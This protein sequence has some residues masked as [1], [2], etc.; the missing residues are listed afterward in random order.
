MASKKPVGTF[1]HDQLRIIGVHVYSWDGGEAF[2][3][4]TNVVSSPPPPRLAD[5]SIY[6]LSIPYTSISFVL[7]FI[8]PVISHL[9]K[10]FFDRI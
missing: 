4:P 9:N 7:T 5:S 3:S 8:T 10:R 1:H 2:L 6:C